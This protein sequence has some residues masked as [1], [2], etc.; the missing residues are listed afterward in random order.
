MFGNAQRPNPRRS[1]RSG[2]QS[3]RTEADSSA[4]AQCLGLSLGAATNWHTKQHPGPS[5]PGRVLACET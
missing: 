1:V 3:S 4:L 5:P 2:Q